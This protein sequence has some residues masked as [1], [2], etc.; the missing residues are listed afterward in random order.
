MLLSQYLEQK[1]EALTAENKSKP[2]AKKKLTVFGISVL[3]LLLVPLA[4][5]KAEIATLTILGVVVAVAAIGAAVK[6]FFPEMADNAF[7]HAINALLYAVFALIYWLTK[8]AATL[9]DTVIKPEAFYALMSSPGVVTGWS[10]VRDIFNIIF[11][12]ALLFS[13]FC[14][15]FQV[16][17]YHI[18]NVILWVVLMALLVNFS[19]PISRFIVDASNI[20][21]Y[22]LLKNGIETSD[23]TISPLFA[24]V[25]NF[26]D[27]AQ[28][29]MNKIGDGN[30]NK[31]FMLL[32]MIVF[33]F[34]LF[35]TLF[36]FAINFLIRLLVL[37]VLIILSPAG[38]AL[39]A[40]PSTSHYADEWWS[41][42]FKYAFM[43]P[44]MAFFLYLTFSIFLSANAIDG[45]E[46]ESMLTGEDTQAAVVVMVY[47]AIPVTFMWV[48]LIM[49]SK[50][51]GMGSS[52]AMGWAKAT[53]NKLKQW[54]KAGA[55]AAWAGTGVPGGVKQA[56][57]H[58]VSDRMDSNRRK[59][60]TGIAAGL[61]VSGARQKAMMATVEDYKKNNYTDDELKARASKGDH[62][63]A[64][65]LGDKGE[66]D[67]KSYN[68]YM[69]RA[70]QEKHGEAK[71]LRD[72]VNAKVKGKR[73]DIV[74]NNKAEDAD[75]ISKV[76]ADPTAIA[77]GVVDEASARQHIVNREMGKLSAK[78]WEEQK[79]DDISRSVDPADTIE[80]QER[81]RRTNEA[82]NQSYTNMT[83]AAKTEINKRLSGQSAAALRRGHGTADPHASGA[84]LDIV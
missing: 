27:I 13:A 9:L 14:T 42:L 56:W 61:R 46:I 12:F 38:F 21:M 29:T 79:W 20:T 49:S 11:I 35:V 48:G 63:A 40:F 43:G 50:M 39:K 34:I 22:F 70:K 77:A 69:A 64:Y 45:S 23:G 17:K 33:T 57:K 30:Q 74:A 28:N 54:G 4:K 75:E 80:D 44:L 41:A 1:K 7:F 16:S 78:A 18:R 26:G 31:A 51:G 5:V 37:M 15:I 73:A 53:G 36:A 19:F 32:V 24:M 67:Q 59:M 6:Y 65:L 25:T 84:G 76:M 68:A 72:S 62:A 66:M 58:H 82:V 52:M 10:T 60:E 47:Y 81:Q 3:L 2:A 55:G 83:R 71:A 8:I